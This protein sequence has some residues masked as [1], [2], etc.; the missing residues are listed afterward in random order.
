MV[1]FSPF[2]RSDFFDKLLILCTQYYK[3]QIVDIRQGGYIDVQYADGEIDEDLFY[4]HVKRFQPYTIGETVS[5]KKR[6]GD[7]F[8]EG[9]VVDIHP[10]DM[11]SI[12]FFEEN[13]ILKVPHS[14]L[15][16]HMDEFKVGDYVE[17]P[18][19]YYG[20][21]FSAVIIDINDQG[22]GYTVLFDDG[23]VVH[24]LPSSSLEHVY[25]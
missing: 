1:F 10:G 23:D 4:Y 20:E 15:R 6:H 16:R 25:Q 13:D 19:G 17:A 14:F 21:K 8:H 3:G 5:A 22:N 11:V 9:I 18:F 7:V 2:H 12:E 24:D